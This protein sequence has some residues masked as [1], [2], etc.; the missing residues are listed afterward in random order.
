MW[1]H[2]FGELHNDNT[3]LDH[4]K[5]V[6]SL[7]WL[8]QLV[9]RHELLRVQVGQEVRN[10]FVASLKSK[11]IVLEEIVEVILERVEQ[12]AHHPVSNFGL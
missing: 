8:H 11:V 10:E 3:L 4:V 5:L 6:D 12:F 9:L 7:A 2:F 1:K